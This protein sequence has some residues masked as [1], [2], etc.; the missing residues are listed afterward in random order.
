MRKNEENSEIESL[1]QFYLIQPNISINPLFIMTQ[2]EENKGKKRKIKTKEVKI[3]PVGSCLSRYQS[4]S[5]FF[6]SLLKHNR[7]HSPKFCSIIFLI[8]YNKTTTPSSPPPA[9]ISTIILSTSPPVNPCIYMLAQQPSPIH[10]HPEHA[11]INGEDEDRTRLGR[12]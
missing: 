5:Y 6:F 8:C 7:I 3:S 2:K 9:L 1:G 4:S 11:K 12:L 10:H